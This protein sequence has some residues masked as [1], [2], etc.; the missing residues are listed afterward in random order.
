MAILAPFIQVYLGEAIRENEITDSLLSFVVTDRVGIARDTASLQVVNQY[1]ALELSDF[2][3]VQTLGIWLPRIIRVHVNGVE[4][5]AFFAE[6]VEE[7]QLNDTISLFTVALVRFSYSATLLGL[8]R[9]VAVGTHLL[10]L[11]PRSDYDCPTEV[12]Y[13]L[14]GAKVQDAG[15]FYG[16]Y[17]TNICLSAATYT[18]A[19]TQLERIGLGV[20]ATRID[21]PTTLQLETGVT[22]VQAQVIYQLAQGIGG[23]VP[24]IFDLCKRTT[25]GNA[26]ITE[27]DAIGWRIATADPGTPALW[28]LW[29]GE[30]GMQLPDDAI[31]Q[32]PVNDE[33][34]ASF[35]LADDMNEYTPDD[36]F[37]GQYLT[38]M[39]EPFTT[40][41]EREAYIAANKHLRRVGN[42]ASF[43]VTPDTQI[44]TLSL[45][46]YRTHVVRVE[47]IRRSYSPEDYR[48]ECR[49]RIV[50][51]G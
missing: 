7:R 36:T 46:S 42:V 25:L 51:E 34:I 26:N 35:R 22:S 4:A 23:L 24:I 1:R 39:E 40:L 14:N 49:G 3:P 20:Y 50:S 15:T 11:F 16:Q 18:E 10:P 6:G 8:L 27:L 43:E 17:V 33:V 12:A 28:R 45:V 44:R 19:I 37:F 31:E 2:Y 9:R 13:W 48:L 32:R 29:R 30:S 41:T 38:R 47:E 21:S 5:G